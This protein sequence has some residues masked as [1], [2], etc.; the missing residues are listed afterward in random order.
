MIIHRENKSAKKLIPI[1]KS[2]LV[3][4]ILNMIG[5]NIGVKFFA[6]FKNRDQIFCTFIRPNIE[7]FISDFEFY[8]TSTP[9]CRNPENFDPD[10]LY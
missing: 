7:I 2:E 10:L 3:H 4:F 1:F 9:S 6:L 5:Q 8:R